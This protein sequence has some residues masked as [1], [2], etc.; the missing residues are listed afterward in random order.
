MFMIRHAESFKNT[1]GDDDPTND[2]LTPLG[3]SQ[4]EFTA[5]W[6][7][8][9]PGCCTAVLTAAEVRCQQTAKPILKALGLEAATVDANLTSKL[10]LTEEGTGGHGHKRLETPE[11]RAQR[12]LRSV[13]AF[14]AKTHGNVVARSQLPPDSCDNKRCPIPTCFSPLR[15]PSIQHHHQPPFQIRPMPWSNS[16]M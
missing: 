6:L 3:E 9:R 7:K 1:L 8:S 14:L 11:E 15:Q 10:N 2:R 12:G 16:S 5:R 13:Q 4:A